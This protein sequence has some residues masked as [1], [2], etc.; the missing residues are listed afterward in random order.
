MSAPKLSKPSAVMPI[1]TV[2]ITLDEIA[3]PGWQAEM[4]LNIRAHAYDE[5]LSQDPDKFWSAF[6]DIVIGWNF[7]NEDGTPMPLPKD[8]LGPRDLPIDVLN[9]LVLRYVEAMADSAAI[10]KARESGSAITSRTNGAGPSSG[11]A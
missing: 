4:R 5:F 3:Y 11:P 8:G 1:K 6:T 10:P 2:V 9:T 7:V